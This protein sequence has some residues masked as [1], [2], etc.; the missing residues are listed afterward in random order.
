MSRVN[1]H[2]DGEVYHSAMPERRRR[3]RTQA[4]VG[5]IGLAAVLGPGA[6]FATAQ[7]LDRQRAATVTQDA[8]VLVPVMPSE[9]PAPTPSGTSG[10]PVLPVRSTMSAVRQSTSPTPVPSGPSALAS[11]FSG[12]SA[13]DA[14]VIEQNFT[15]ADGTIRVQAA[16]FDLSG[17]KDLTMAGDNG[18]PVG[19]A[20]CTQ[21]M[22]FA[23][24]PGVREVP[25]MLLCWRTSVDRS[26]ITM[27]VAAAGRPARE[28][29]LELLD[30][31]WVN[32][33]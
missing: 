20:R 8:G 14:G 25:S 26:V 33:G 4:I 11:G 9:E 27:A 19:T 13:Q 3:R 18:R 22:R 7:I 2:D 5:A 6:Y 32:L 1:M 29:S 23:G 17:Q 28:R 31:Q 24:D 16:R 21:N 30:R 10:S 12:L 15:T